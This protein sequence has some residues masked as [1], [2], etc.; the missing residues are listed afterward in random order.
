MRAGST[1]PPPLSAAETERLSE[2]D[3]LLLR[4]ETAIDAL[5]DRL[6]DPSWAVRRA[7]VSSLASLGDAAARALSAALVQRR[8]SEARIAA[9]VDA[10][11]ACTGP[12]TSDLVAALHGDA[13]PAVVADVAQI[14]GRRRATGATGTLIALTRHR[15]DN[16]AVAAIEALGRVGGRAAIDALVDTVRTGGFFRTFPAIDVLG[17]SG[18]PRA[19]APLAELLASQHLAAEAARA[20]GRTG[21]RAAVAPLARLLTGGSAALARVAAVALG[22]LELRHGQRLGDSGVIAQSLRALAEPSMVRRL[23]DALDDADTGEQVAICRM[24]SILGGAE[25]T[26]AL[27]RLLDGDPVVAA[28]A[29]RALVSLDELAE[30]ELLIALDE[31]DAPRRLILLPM[32]SR[33]SA[34]PMV[35]R[36]LDDEDAGVRAA[37]CDAL[38]RIGAPAAVAPVFKLL[39]DSNPRVVQS[40]VGAIQALGGADTER[41][42]LEAARAPW[43]SVRRAALRIVGYFGWPRSLSVVK[44]AL[45]DSDERVREAALQSLPFIDDPVAL[46]ELLAVATGPNNRLRAVATRALGQSR[47]ALRVTAALLR[48]LADPDP[49]VRYYACQS[50]GRLGVDTATPAIARLLDDPAG[51]VRVAAIEAL[52]HLPGEIAFAALRDAAAAADPD[53]RRAALVGLGISRRPEAEPLLT[54][55]MASPDVA[56]RLVALAA[57]ADF[58]DSDAVVAGLERAVADVQDTVRHAAFGFLA[59]RPGAHATRLLVAAL[60]RRHHVDAEDVERIVEALAVPAAGRSEAL[61]ASLAE[62]DDEVAPL[63]LSALARAR[64]ADADA[65]IRA[66]LHGANPAARKAAA[67]VVAARGGDGLGELRRLATSDPDPEVRRVIALLLS[68]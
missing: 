38:A 61:I 13:A 68:R 54:A 32:V 30:R 55:A 1:S 41:L 47:P 62:A 2:V 8:D 31:G 18:D 15:D 42:T 56:T 23:I 36:C 14:L 3:G 53:V 35:L 66:A 65:A 40:A 37:A 6:A 4:G 29:G 20:L 16:V 28:A 12:T 34:L 49:W 52:S 64:R 5:I 7:V 11:A 33:S 57:V 24:L 26:A 58:G 50:L 45:A 19:V 27:G 51:Q 63:I 60:G 17:R 21:E 48:G 44:A 10:L 46:D 25:A 43:P 39:A 67:S 9:T 22:E 59:A